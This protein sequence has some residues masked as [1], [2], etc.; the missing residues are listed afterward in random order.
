[1]DLRIRKTGWACSMSG[2]LHGFG[3][4]VFKTGYTSRKSWSLTAACGPL[5]SSPDPDGFWVLGDVIKIPDGCCWRGGTRRVPALSPK[6]RLQLLDKPQYWTPMKSSFL[7]G[8]R[9]YVTSAFADQ[10]IGATTYEQP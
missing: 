3:P 7:V 6:K 5:Y 8:V 1:M 4:I 9:Y 10:E 2:T